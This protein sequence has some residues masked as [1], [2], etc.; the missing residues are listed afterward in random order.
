MS[1]PIRLERHGEIAEI[2]LNVPERRNALSDAMWT[3]IP[4]LIDTVETEPDLK[5]AI[6]HGGSAGAFAAGADISEFERIYATPESAARAAETIATAL[7]RIERCKKPVLAAIE[8]ACVGGGVSVALACDMRIAG[9]GARF[10]ITPGKLGL[11]YPFD[12]TR[13]LVD[14]VGAPA[15][16]DILY[17][18]RLFGADEAYRLRLADRLTEKGKALACARDLATAMTAISQWSI[19]ASKQMISRVLTGQRAESDETRDMFTDGVQGD[20]F[21]EGYRA[22]LEKRPARF[23]YR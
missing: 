20:D 1:D 18:G 23:N 13:R 7:N 4:G 6:I 21:Q 8:G 16:R 15:A 22:F 17:T 3:A 14:T 9:K 5:I 12:D 10:A 19:R 11:V 2:I